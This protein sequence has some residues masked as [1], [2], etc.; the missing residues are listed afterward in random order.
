M[1]VQGEIVIEFVDVRGG[2]R[3]GGMTGLLQLVQRGRGRGRGGSR[4]DVGVGEGVCVRRGRA[5][6][7][8]GV[9][10]HVGLRLLQAWAGRGIRRDLRIKQ[11]LPQN[12]VLSLGGVRVVRRVYV[13]RMLCASS[14]PVCGAVGTV[15][16]VDGVDA[17]DCGGCSLQHLLCVCVHGRAKDAWHKDPCEGAPQHNPS[18]PPIQS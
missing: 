15:G 18:P 6:D 5:S 7:W 9:C 2:G 11:L 12:V 17:S 4:R 10:R 13:M 3:R 16:G 14:G 8:I 1:G